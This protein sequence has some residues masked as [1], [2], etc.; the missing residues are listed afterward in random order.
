V[1]TGRERHEA[2]AL[3][4]RDACWEIFYSNTAPPADVVQ[5]LQAATE[6]LGKMTEEETVA[7]SV[8][9][10][11]NFHYED[12]PGSYGKDAPGS[13]SSGHKAA[14]CLGADV[15]EWVGANPVGL[16]REQREAVGRRVNQ[17]GAQLQRERAVLAKG[18]ELR[19]RVDALAAE[20]RAIEATIRVLGRVYGDTE[21]TTEGTESTED[22]D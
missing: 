5:R 11:V 2:A 18:D 3:A 22:G 19:Q 15:L 9:A 8:A 16:S 12:E 10:V 14:W 13:H 4:V 20:V 6:T 17:V 7:F 21:G 1:T